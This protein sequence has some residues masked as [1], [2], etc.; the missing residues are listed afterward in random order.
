MIRRNSFLD[1][2][3]EKYVARNVVTF[4]YMLY[5]ALEYLLSSQD[6]IY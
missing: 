6:R 4:L 1:L 2:P 3:V 5:L